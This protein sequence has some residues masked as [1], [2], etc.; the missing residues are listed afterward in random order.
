[1]ILGVTLVGEEAVS[2]VESLVGVEESV[3]VV[4][5]VVFFV[6]VDLEVVDPELEVVLLEPVGVADEPLDVG[7]LDMVPLD[8]R[9][10][11]EIAELPPD[12]DVSHA[13]LPLLSVKQFTPSWQQSDPHAV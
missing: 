9:I 5:L 8:V 4:F 1:M 2:D 13:W 12:P 3:A 6:V 11:V 7:P 10:R